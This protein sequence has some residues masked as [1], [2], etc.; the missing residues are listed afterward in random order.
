MKI[1]QQH[2]NKIIQLYFKEWKS[3]RSINRTE[4]HSRN[5]IRRYVD[6]H[7]QKLIKDILDKSHAKADKIYDTWFITI[8]ISLLLI[9]IGFL[10]YWIYTLINY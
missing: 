5:T 8:A 1:S 7:E 2:I 4:W 10:F 6:I 3:I 9:I